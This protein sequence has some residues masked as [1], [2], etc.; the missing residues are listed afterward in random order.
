MNV[1]LELLKDEFKEF[2]EKGRKVWDVYKKE[3]FIFRA[4]FLICVY[5]YPYKREFIVRVN[6]WV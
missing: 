6:I 3:E 5:D 4:V 2:W 1:Y